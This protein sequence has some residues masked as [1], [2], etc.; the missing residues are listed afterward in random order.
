MLK[1]TILSKIEK[2]NA[3]LGKIRCFAPKLFYTFIY[4]ISLYIFQF[5]P[6]KIS[7]PIPAKIPPFSFLDYFYT[8]EYFVDCD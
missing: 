5:F 4:I 2:S 8:I 7:N 1:I 6:C 3:T